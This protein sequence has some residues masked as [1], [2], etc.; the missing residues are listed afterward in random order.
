MVVESIP[1][2]IV[3]DGSGIADYLDECSNKA[4]DGLDEDS[5]K[6][7]CGEPEDRNYAQML[8]GSHLSS[9]TKMYFQDEA[10][11][12]ELGLCCIV[13]NAFSKG[14]ASL[15]LPGLEE[16]QYVLC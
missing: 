12:S 7:N 3:N 10:A 6:T 8:S 9:G 11:S 14:H 16:S 1:D 2:Y 13:G 5:N 4:N 15:E